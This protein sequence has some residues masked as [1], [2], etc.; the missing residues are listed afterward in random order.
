MGAVPESIEVSIEVDSRNKRVI[1]VATGSSELRTRDVEIRELEES[2]L[3]EIVARSLKTDTRDLNID[4]RTSFLTAVSTVVRSSYFFGLIRHETKKVRIIDREGVIRLQL[5]DCEA[6]GVEA[7][8][9]KRTVRDF[10]EKLT[11]YG[12]AGALVPDIFILTGARIID[13]TGLAQESQIMAI[14]DIELKKLP[15]SEPVIVLAAKK[16]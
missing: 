3:L 16:K 5:N 14:L 2:S 13:M 11:V 9:V 10:I 12:D 4:G 1:A 8:Q 7:A 15:S 6:S